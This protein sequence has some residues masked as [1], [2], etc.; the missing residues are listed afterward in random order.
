MQQLRTLTLGI[1]VLA[2]AAACTPSGTAT[3][4]PTSGGG[5][6]AP[7]ATTA[8]GTPSAAASAAATTAPATTAPMTQAPATSGTASA[9]PSGT[10]TAAYAIF[11]PG[12]GSTTVQGGATLFGAAGQT[13]VVIGVI[14]SGTETMAASIQAGTCDSLTPEIAHRL[15]DVASGASTTTVAVD[16]ATLL[17]TPY[18][19]N[20]SVAGSETESSISCGEIKPLPLP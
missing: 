20:I 9:P 14:S 16:L 4:A 15:T 11:E 1:A 7:A 18:A 6:T 3:S 8:A 5:A 13:M 2:M 17:A 12:T 10:A 19:I